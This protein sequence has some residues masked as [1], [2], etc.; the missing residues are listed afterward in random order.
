MPKDSLWL[1]SRVLLDGCGA[2]FL[3]Y[4]MICSVVA[5]TLLTASLPH[6]FRSRKLA[7]RPESLVPAS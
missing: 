6:R 1:V 4:L 5:L 3:L 7:G 2:L